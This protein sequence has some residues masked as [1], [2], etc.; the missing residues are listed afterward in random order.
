MPSSAVL[1]RPSQ[2]PRPA[3]LFLSPPSSCTCAA[4]AAFASQ[5]RL[6][7]SPHV[8]QQRNREK[9][10]CVLPSATRHATVVLPLASR[11]WRGRGPPETCGGGWDG[12]RSG[13]LAVAPTPP[14]STPVEWQPCRG[15]EWEK[16]RQSQGSDARRTCR[17]LAWAATDRWGG[18]ETCSPAR[19]RP[20]DRRH[21]LPVSVVADAAQRR[22]LRPGST[23]V[24]V[25]VTVPIYTTHRRTH[26]SCCTRMYVLLHQPAHVRP[27]TSAKDACC[28]KLLG[29][30]IQGEKILV[31]EYMPNKSL[32]AFLFGTI[33][34]HPCTALFRETH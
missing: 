16:A 14:P 2:P 29:C 34:I 5:P 21:L 30:C 25:G 4:R 15:A 19:R 7:P 23:Y 20:P 18:G 27:A 17:V 24:Y 8:S 28:C 31:Y 1:R 3:S 13:S 11:P 9:V 22:R 12:T 6:D 10:V 26:A 32:D 33:R